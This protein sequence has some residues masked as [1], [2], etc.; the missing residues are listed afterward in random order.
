M[1]I[2]FSYDNLEAIIDSEG[3]YFLLSAL[4]FSSNSTRL[5]RFPTTDTNDDGS[6]CT[7]SPATNQAFLFNYNKQPNIYF[8]SLLFESVFIYILEN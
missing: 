3:L 5:S 2:C 7:S 4:I 6:G 1:Q 8:F